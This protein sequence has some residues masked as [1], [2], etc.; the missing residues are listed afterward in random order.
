[1]INWLVYYF[2]FVA[3]VSVIIAI[4]VIKLQL[5][6]PLRLLALIFILIVSPVI[7]SYIV[8]TYFNPLPETMVP[9]LIGKSL[10]E[11]KEI[12]EI[13]DL[14]LKV[15]A[16]AGSSEIISNQRPEEGRVVKV[17][18]TVFVTLGKKIPQAEI[19]ISSFEGE[20]EDDSFMFEQQD[21]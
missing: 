20:S 21:E 8:A 14:D 2:I 15:E 13:L 18:R 6:S 7:L 11:A 17:G 3:V 5:K 16:R 19:P 1:M 12:T 4:V 9:D 10:S